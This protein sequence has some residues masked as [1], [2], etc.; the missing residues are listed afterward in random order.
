LFSQ[1]LKVILKQ[2]NELQLKTALIIFLRLAQFKMTEELT[3]IIDDRQYKYFAKCPSLIQYMHLGKQTLLFM[4][5][6]TLLG[7]TYLINTYTVP[8][9]KGPNPSQAL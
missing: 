9:T 2:L 6:Q 8:C 3:G 1:F 7:L 5:L 4:G